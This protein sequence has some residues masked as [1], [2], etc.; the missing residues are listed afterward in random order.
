MGVTQ[1]SS[2]Y[3]FEDKIA[4]F[5]RFKN[6]GFIKTASSSHRITDSAAGAT[7]FAS[8]VKTYNAAIGVD[9]DTLP[10][11]TI[12]EILAR[13]NWKTG[14]VATS[15]ITHATPASFYAHVAH[16]KMEEEI[17]KQLASANIDIFIGG[18]EKFFGSRS[19][20]INFL[21]HLVDH[22][23]IVKTQIDNYSWDEKLSEKEAHLLSENAMM[24]M[25]EGRGNF[26]MKASNYTISKLNQGDQRFFVMIEA[27]QIDWGG[28]ANDHEYILSE[29]MDFDETINAV[30]DFAEKDGETLVIV[31]ADHETGGYALSGSKEAKHGVIGTFSTGGHTAALIPVFAFGPGAEKF[32]G[33]YENTGIFHKMM[34]LV[35]KE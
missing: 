19:D 27:S 6:I 18:G 34:E 35:K 4:S 17:A 7:A 9:S 30:L 8:G 14:L 24:K 33:I 25:S 13:E 5:D 3:A 23:Y 1:I 29:M 22:G 10:V 26:L 28:H 20:S 32:Q 16:R 21:S 11:E 12:V 2:L 15:S 31:T